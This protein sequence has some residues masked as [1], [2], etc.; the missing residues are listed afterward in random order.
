MVFPESLDV[1]FRNARKRKEIDKLKN[2]EL[3]KCCNNVLIHSR[4]LRKMW[5]FFEF[6]LKR[7]GVNRKLESCCTDADE[8]VST[9]DCQLFSRDGARP[10]P[11]NSVTNYFRLLLAC[12]ALFHFL[13]S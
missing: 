8:N 1:L 4:V 11:K 12:W 5:P 3:R 7:T 2:E 6:I 9:L 10:L 13:N